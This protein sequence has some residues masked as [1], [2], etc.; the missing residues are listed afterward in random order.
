MHHIYSVYNSPL[1]VIIIFGQYCYLEHTSHV[2]IY[3]LLSAGVLEGCWH[4]SIHCICCVI[5]TTNVEVSAYFEATSLQ[6]KPISSSDK[7]SHL[8]NREKHFMSTSLFDV[9]YIMLP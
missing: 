4:I 9:P 3:L 7:L 2:K 5:L 8:L 6:V 1:F